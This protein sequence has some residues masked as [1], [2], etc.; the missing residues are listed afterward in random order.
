MTPE[1]EV[2]YGLFAED[3]SSF[4]LGT[5]VKQHFI[6]GLNQHSLGPLGLNLSLHHGCEDDFFPK[7]FSLFTYCNFSLFEIFLNLRS[8]G[9]SYFFLFNIPFKKA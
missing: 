1:S 4:Y 8:Q 7:R 6:H 5:D 3:H 9:I 2:G